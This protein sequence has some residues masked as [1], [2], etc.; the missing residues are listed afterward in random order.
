MAR[1]S[2]QRPLNRVWS[3]FADIGY[4]RNS[5]QQP[6]SA[7]QLATCDFDNSNPT[8]PPCPGVDAN[9][10]TTGFAGVGV[11]RALGHDFH[12]FV[13]YQFNELSF[14]HSYCGGV[15][16]CSRISNRHV[17]TIGL[18]WTPRPIRID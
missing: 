6:L 2:V 8:L 1:L 14:D 9:S 12:M 15:P 18:D 10:F 3:G 4:S 13:S 7:T 5:R 17:G 11:H 16:V